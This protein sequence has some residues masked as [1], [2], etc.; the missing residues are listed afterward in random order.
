MKRIFLHFWDEYPMCNH[1][2][3][4]KLQNIGSFLVSVKSKKVLKSSLQYTLSWSY[5]MK[6]KNT[7][8]YQKLLNLDNQKILKVIYHYVLNFLSYLVKD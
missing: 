5:N 4:F 6:R 3:I 8:V 7:Y 2:N 1:F